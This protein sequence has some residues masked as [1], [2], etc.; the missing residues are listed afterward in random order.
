MP[1]RQEGRAASSQRHGRLSPERRTLSPGVVV[2]AL[3]SDV[4]GPGNQLARTEPPPLAA[5]GDKEFD[6]DGQGSSDPVGAGWG[7]DDL[8]SMLLQGMQKKR[9]QYVRTCASPKP[10]LPS[11][12]PRAAR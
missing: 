6:F 2:S 4:V 1:A 11:L 10:L 5:Q 8:D 12:R 9:Q 7:M 3:S